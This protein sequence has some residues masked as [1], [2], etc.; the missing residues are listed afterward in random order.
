MRDRAKGIGAEL[1]IESKIGAG[2]QVI[3]KL[4][5]TAMEVQR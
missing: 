1:R 2:S 4:R 3:V 5:N